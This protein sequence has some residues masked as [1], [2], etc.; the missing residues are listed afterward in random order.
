MIQRWVGFRV[1]ARN[2]R[3]SSSESHL[4]DNPTGAG[5]VD[6]P[7]VQKP[8][9]NDQ[10]SCERYDVSEAIEAMEGDEILL[11]SLFKIFLETKTNLIH[12]M[13]EGIAIGRPA[14]FPTESPSIERRLIRLERN[15]S[16]QKS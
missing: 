14:A 4:Q 10:E 16:G 8:L 5:I 7:I 11:H 1:Q 15:L 13:K 12:G 9:V 2:D 6:P 3:Y